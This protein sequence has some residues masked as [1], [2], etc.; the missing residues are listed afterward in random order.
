M[1]RGLKVRGCHK[2]IKLVRTRDTIRSS[3]RKIL[4]AAKRPSPATLD[5]DRE[6][7][8]R[9]GSMGTSRDLVGGA[10][11]PRAYDYCPYCYPPL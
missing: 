5:P 10:P 3:I 11:C 9:W 2:V 1:E 6:R 8:G 7:E 4:T